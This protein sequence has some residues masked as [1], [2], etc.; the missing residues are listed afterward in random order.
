V[1]TV[2]RKKQ[3]NEWDRQTDRQTGGLQHCLMPPKHNDIKLTTYRLVLFRI[4]IH[5]SLPTVHLDWADRAANGK[6]IKRRSVRRRTR[7]KVEERKVPA[8]K[9]TALFLY[10]PRAELAVRV[11]H[12]QSTPDNR[13]L[14]ELLSPASNAL[15]LSF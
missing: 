11:P 3:Y 13:L 2:E 5:P 14:D 1:V 15:C 4:P 12:R 9:Q 7:V 6:T 10:L 8:C